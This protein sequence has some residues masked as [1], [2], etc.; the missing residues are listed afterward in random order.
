MRRAI[1]EKK[2]RK[3]RL[4]S[5]GSFLLSLGGFLCFCGVLY[6]CYS[7][8]LGFVTDPDRFWVSR[9]SVNGQLK[10]IDARDIADE[11][12][13]M[14]GGKNIVTLDLVPLHNAL[15]QLPWV[16]KVSVHK[17]FPDLIE[18]E[19]VEHFVSARW[20]QS[21][22]YDAQTRSVFYP[23]LKDFHEPLVTLSAPH[24]D[25]APEL[26][27]HAFQF[28]QLTQNTN[29]MIEEVQLDAVRGYRVRLNGDVW[30]ILGRE[31]SPDLPLIRLK[32]FILAFGSTHLK[33]SDV[34]Y[35]DMRYDNGF[36]V[37]ERTPEAES[38][39][40]AGAGAATTAAP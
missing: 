27:E 22:L 37:G 23:D 16:A 38:E 2:H 20:K 32:R 13:K 19:I 24:D 11:V 35:V 4:R 3:P 15:L 39:T 5:R 36:A 33:L 21:G 18:V 29:Y 7:L 14:V 17:H 30:V 25:L 12:G 9:V 40:D 10:Q 28:I 8:F 31:S 6:V 1:L 26:F 34:A